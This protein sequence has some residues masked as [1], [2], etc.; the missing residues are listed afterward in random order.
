MADAEAQALDRAGVFMQEVEA[1]AEDGDIREHIADE[2]DEFSHGGVLLYV[3]RDGQWIEGST[4]LP[5][6]DGDGCALLDKNARTWMVCS[7]TG[8]LGYA[9]VVGQAHD[10]LV[11]HRKPLV[12]GGLLALLL[13]SLGSILGGF[14]IARWSLSPLTKLR[15]AIRDVKRLSND[16]GPLPRSGTTEVDIFAA[17]LDEVLGR[18]GQEAARSQHF[19]AD[20]AHELRTPL[21]KLRAE[22]E[23]LAEESNGDHGSRLLRLVARIDTLSELVD[24]LLLL[25]SPHDAIR[26]PNLVSLAATVESAVE[27]GE[28]ARIEVRAQDDGLVLGDATVLSAMV[29]NAVGN[30]L[31]F[32][33]GPIR[34][35]V[36]REGDE[37]VFRVDDTGPGLPPHLRGAV[38]ERFVRGPDNHGAPG[39]GVGL[40]LIAHIVQAHRGTAAFVDGPPGAHLEIRLPAHGVS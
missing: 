4:E 27:H 18:L 35:S 3:A 20:A 36:C 31:K 13:V 40:A 37:I 22:L 17:T 33:E 10:R 9:V 38:F 24:Q 39:H 21:T 1:E 32:S 7:V 12:V 25:A 28:A 6:Y 5:A 14:W 34:A 15:T 2:I 23:L 26:S 16:H 8:E 30:A 19:A 11:A 29:S